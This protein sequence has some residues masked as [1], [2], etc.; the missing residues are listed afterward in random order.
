MKTN[1]SSA[2]LTGSAVSGGSSPQSA[3]ETEFELLDA[4]SRAVT[5]VVDSISPAV[6]SINIQS[7]DS[8]G[9][10]SQHGLGSGIVITP[11]GYILTNSHVVRNGTHI[12]VNFSDGSQSEATL[13]GD[14]P[15]T[16]LALVRAAVS[17]LAFAGLGDSSRLKAGQLV[18]AV[19]SP[20]GFEST[21]S[22]G[23]VSA[24]GRS[25]RSETGRLI[26]NIIQHTAPLNPGN[27]GGPLLD[28]R[29]QV[30][31]INTAVIARAQ[32]I[33][34]SIPSTM[35]N[36]VVSHLM[37]YG[38]VRRGFLGIMARS[39]PI[40]RRLARFLE[41]SAEIGVEIV[42]LESG[43]PAERAGLHIGDIVVGINGAVTES[44]DDLHRVLT[45]W[46]FS[47]ALHLLVVRRTEKLA[48]D[49]MP[50]ETP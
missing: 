27:S 36:R 7:K 4:Y 12:Q 45:E 48:L 29:R 46:P 40:D 47:D 14:D 17:G 6:A 28:A 37:A 22:T 34:F 26:E 25:F 30:I 11:D 39:R 33:G 3:A 13:V 31:G 19:G 24:L 9:S 44:V 18:I 10:R 23:V 21:V 20:L 49:V 42:N 35:A 43:G 5:A 41:L 2:A 8:S 1:I 15:S 16:D 32:G 38:H 50:T